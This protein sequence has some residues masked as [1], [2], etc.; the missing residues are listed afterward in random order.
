LRVAIDHQHF[1]EP[2]T[3]ADSVL[4]G[5]VESEPLR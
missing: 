5:K 2:Q 3:L 4:L 1:P